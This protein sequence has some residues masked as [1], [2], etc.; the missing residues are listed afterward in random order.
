MRSFAIYVNPPVRSRVV[1]DVE[2][3][4]VVVVGIF[5]A[6]G[7]AVFTYRSGRMQHRYRQLSGRGGVDMGNV[8]VRDEED[9]EEDA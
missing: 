6:V 1:L 5:A 2:L 3:L 8:D 7:V 4:G 9:D